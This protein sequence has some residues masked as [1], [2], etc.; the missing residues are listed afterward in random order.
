MRARDKRGD[1]LTEPRA[2]IN[3]T[4]HIPECMLK[5]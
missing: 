1:Q 2:K 4:A 3:K 5:C